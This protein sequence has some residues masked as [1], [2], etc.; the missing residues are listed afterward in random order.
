M[1]YTQG[2]IG[3]IFV[4][5]FENGDK[6]VENLSAFAKKEK[7]KS[8]VMLFIGALKKG[9][10]V[11]GPKR[12][13]VPPSPNTVAFKDAWEVLGIGTIFT[14]R[15]GPQLHLHASMGQKLKVLTGC[16]RGKSEVFLVLEA[17]VFEL[18]GVKASKDFDLQSGINMLKVEGFSYI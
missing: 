1:K 17:V 16:I 4:V 12:P 11:T 13:V 10:I 7:L 3:R 15:K 8:A 2:N 6:I 18:N 5:K 9:D 14:N